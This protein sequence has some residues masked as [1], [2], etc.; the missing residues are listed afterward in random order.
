VNQ[1]V[2]VTVPKTHP[3][4]LLEL[5]GAQHELLLCVEETPS[6]SFM[7]SISTF[8]RRQKSQKEKKIPGPDSPPQTR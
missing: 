3:L 2:P 8:L 5:V 4:V 7:S 6:L 1:E